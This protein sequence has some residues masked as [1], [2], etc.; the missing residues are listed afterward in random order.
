VS[1]SSEAV[2]SGIR[3]QVRSRFLDGRSRPE[4]KQWLF[5]YT[6]RITNESSRTVQLLGRHWIITDGDGLV[7]EVR[8]KGVVGEQPVIRPGESYEYTSGCPLGTPLGS[9]HGTYSLSSEDG[10][11]FDVV[12]APFVLSEPYAIN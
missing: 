7:E 3:V 2:T 9:M 8:G 5:A 10:D 1:T 4:E 6:V 11:L 12:I